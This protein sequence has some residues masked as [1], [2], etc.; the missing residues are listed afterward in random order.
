MAAVKGRRRRSNDEILTVPMQGRVAIATREKARAVADTLGV[1]MSKYLDELIAKDELDEDGRPLWWR[2][3]ELE[4]QQADPQQVL[5][6][7]G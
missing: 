3:R 6:L 4:Q 7:T 5:P 1:S 2:E